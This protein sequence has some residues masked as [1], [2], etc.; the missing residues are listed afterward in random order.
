MSV[1]TLSCCLVLPY[2]NN[3]KPLLYNGIARLKPVVGLW[4][5]L[6]YRNVV[7]AVAL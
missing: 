6:L 5:V 4:V 2:D 3:Y 7:A 1:S